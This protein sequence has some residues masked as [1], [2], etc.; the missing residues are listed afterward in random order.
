MLLFSRTTQLESEILF[1]EI[2][3][4]VFEYLA[5]NDHRL[6]CRAVDACQDDAT[7]RYKVGLAFLGDL[8][9]Q[10]ERL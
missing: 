10:G 3:S 4:K 7:S 5:G 1:G 8:E 2:R 6:E 9:L